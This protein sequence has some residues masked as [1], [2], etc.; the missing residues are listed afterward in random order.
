MAHTFALSD[1]FLGGPLQWEASTHHS[2]VRHCYQIHR[3]RSARM[4]HAG[5]WPGLDFCLDDLVFGT[6]GGI[7]CR[8]AR[9]GIL[10]VWSMPTQ[11]SGFCWFAVG[12]KHWVMFKWDLTRAFR[13]G[14]WLSHTDCFMCVTRRVVLERHGRS[15]FFFVS[16]AGIGGRRANERG[17][18]ISAKGEV[19]YS[20]G[21]IW[22]EILSFETFQ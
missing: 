1:V 9:G 5:S 15:P 7:L 16:I 13:Y 14:C 3:A 10:L 2:S 22:L 19:N 4:D 11:N 17:R 20:T 18:S 12:L 6:D 21:R 8:T